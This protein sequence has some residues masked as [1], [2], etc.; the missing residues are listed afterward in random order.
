MRIL[1]LLLFCFHVFVVSGQFESVTNEDFNGDGIDDTL[2]CSFEVGSNFGGRDCQLI[3]GKTKKK[4]GLSSYGCF[5]KIK[6]QITVSPDLLKLENQTFLKLLKSEIL[7]VQKLVADPTLQWLID[8]AYASQT[9][10]SDAVFNLIFKPK[11][12]WRKGVIELPSTY[13]VKMPKDLLGKLFP[14]ANR[15]DGSEGGHGYLVYYGDTHFSTNSN[16]KQ[17]LIE[18]TGNDTYKIFKTGHGVLVKKK[19]AYKWL[20]ISDN[21]QNGS[22]SKLRWASIAQIILLEKH[23][24]IEQSLAPD[25]IYNIYLIDIETGIGGRLRID[26]DYFKGIDINDLSHQ[27]RFSVKDN[28]IRIGPKHN[29]LKFPLKEIKQNLDRF[30]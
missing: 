15:S 20:F 1:I 24:I 29:Q 7:P 27:E 2:K 16:T 5:C 10:G 19:E 4:H 9:T 22:P 8:C 26:F 12:N 14:D 13:Y 23:I 17:D 11:S 18:V 25:S 30:N 6:Q 3:D 21:D 28:E